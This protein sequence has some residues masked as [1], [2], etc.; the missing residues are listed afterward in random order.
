MG[1]NILE[2][3]A[4]LLEIKDDQK[5]KEKVA[6][7]KKARMTK[8][9]AIDEE[10]NSRIYL[11]KDQIRCPFCDVGFRVTDSEQYSVPLE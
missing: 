6:L 2:L 11:G 5:M 7:E 9:V 3:F 1:E 8:L 10:R 4:Y